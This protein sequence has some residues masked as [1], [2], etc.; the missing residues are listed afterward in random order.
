MTLSSLLSSQTEPELHMPCNEYDLLLS[1]RLISLV[2]ACK[3]RFLRD[4]KALY[5]P[6]FSIIDNLLDKKGRG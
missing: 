5:E 2:L 6:S 3:M 1:L 4:Q